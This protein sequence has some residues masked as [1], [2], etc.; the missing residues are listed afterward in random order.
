M[1]VFVTKKP[2]ETRRELNTRQAGKHAKFPAKMS[3]NSVEPQSAS[4]DRRGVVGTR[5]SAQTWLRVVQTGLAGAPTHLG[6]AQIG[7]RRSTDGGGGFVL[8]PPR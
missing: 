8:V 6:I 4:M 1:R 2:N 7:F 3:L 5:L